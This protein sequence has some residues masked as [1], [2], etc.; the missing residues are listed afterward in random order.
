MTERTIFVVLGMRDNRCRELLLRVLRQIEGVREA[1]VSLAQARAMISHEASCA[2]ATLAW[3][4]LSHGYG[5]VLTNSREA[6]FQ[7]EVAT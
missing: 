6:F 2:Q 3:A 4:I 5:V 7:E 1:A